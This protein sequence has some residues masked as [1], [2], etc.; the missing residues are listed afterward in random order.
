MNYK[1]QK[2]PNW[3]DINFR[4]ESSMAWL[5]AMNNACIVVASKKYMSE[6]DRIKDIGLLR[7]I[8]YKLNMTKVDHDAAQNV[9]PDQLD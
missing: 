3:N 9:N 6:E 4:K 1:E 8:I 5:N 2:E 7:D